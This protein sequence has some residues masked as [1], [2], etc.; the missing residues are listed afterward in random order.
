MGI[1]CDMIWRPPPGCHR[2]YSHLR[3]QELTCFKAALCCRHHVSIEI[4]RHTR[5][6]ASETGENNADAQFKPDQ[7]EWPVKGRIATSVIGRDAIFLETVL[8]IIRRRL[9][10]NKHTPAQIPLDVRPTTVLAGDL[11]DH[12]FSARQPPPSSGCKTW[13][14][15]SILHGRKPRP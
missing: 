14:R 2:L 11:F 7:V 4:F 10:G 12:S 1:C 8:N 6:L 13:A 15:S 5:G 3:R 9:K